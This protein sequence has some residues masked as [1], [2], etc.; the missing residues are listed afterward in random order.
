MDRLSS[1]QA[2]IRVAETRS[3][4]RAADQLGISRSAV[5]KLIAALEVETGVRLLHRTT[6]RVYLTAEGEAYLIRVQQALED[7]ECAACMARKEYGQLQGR[8][9]VQIPTCIGRSLLIP[10]LVDFQAKVPKLNLFLS[11][12][13]RHIDLF[14]EGVDCAILIGKLPDSDYIAH[15]LAP[16]EQWTCIHPSLLQGHSTPGH[17]AELSHFP[18]LQYFFPAKP[19]V[20][21]FSFTKDRQTV[22]PKTRQ[23]LAF[24]DD[25]MLLAAGLAGMGVFQTSVD[26]VRPHVETGELIRLFPDW[27]APSYSVHLLTPPSTRVPARVKVFADWITQAFAIQA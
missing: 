3:F 13:D 2:F 5:S 9:W 24:D 22:R 25:S 8:L 16:L 19:V 20:E 11:S 26:V 12:S 23:T 21:P 15:P 10:K 6:R 27:T 18:I 7:L 14:G 17:P 4:T 1:I